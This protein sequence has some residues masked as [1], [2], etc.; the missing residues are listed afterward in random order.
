MGDSMMFLVTLTPSGASVTAAATS[1]RGVLAQAF[2][3]AHVQVEDAGFEVVRPVQLGEPDRCDL[4]SRAAATLG[5]C[6]SDCMAI[7]V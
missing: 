5:G 4:C 7:G 3:T 2:P 1:I 6:C